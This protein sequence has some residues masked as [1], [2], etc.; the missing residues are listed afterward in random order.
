MVDSQSG[1]REGEKGLEVVVEEMYEKKEDECGEVS[2][3]KLLFVNK[4]L[5]SQLF[6]AYVYIVFFNVIHLQ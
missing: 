2:H 1:Q 4:H 6:V 3:W 5:D